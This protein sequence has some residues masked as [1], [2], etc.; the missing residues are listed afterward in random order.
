MTYATIEL[1]VDAGLARLTLNQPALGNPLNEQACA[2]F[3]DVANEI[4]ARSD[5]RAVLLSARGKYFSVGG[6]VKMFAKNIDT[7]A[8]DM[9]RWTV[10]LHMGMARLMRQDAPLVAD[11]HALA[12]G[13]AVAIAAS[14]DYVVCARS[15]RLSAGYGKIAVTCDL[16]A[17]FSLGSRMGI[18]RA[19]RFLLRNEVLSAE[20]ALA[21]GLVDEVVD[22]GETASAA[23]AV[24]R[25]FASGPTRTMGEVRRL[26]LG[27]QSRA[28]EAQLEDEAQALARA[29]ATDDM[30]EGV[31]AFAHGRP[32]QFKGR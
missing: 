28:Y 23:E 11:I 7:L 17:T 18:S 21:V 16:G 5:I 15:A 6:D 24:A 8:L 20:E 19:R 1:T 26:M 13:G 9:R 12:V 29:A 25:E 30:R 2:E 3:G 10:G 31:T 27:L 14:C 4:A 32:A 22:D